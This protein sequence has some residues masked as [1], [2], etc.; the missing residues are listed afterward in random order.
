MTPLA[1]PS[2]SHKERTLALARSNPNATRAKHDD[3]IFTDGTS[4]RLGMSLQHRGGAVQGK[5]SIVKARVLLSD[6]QGLMERI[7]VGN[8]GATV[9]HLVAS[10]VA[11]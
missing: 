3:R 8:Y 5:W 6:P 11:D 2:G 10:S 9:P 7:E 4:S 1:A